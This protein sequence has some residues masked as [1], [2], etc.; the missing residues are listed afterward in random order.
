MTG[1]CFDGSTIMALVTP[2]G[3]RDAW[4]GRAAALDPTT[5]HDTHG[6]LRRAARQKHRAGLSRPLPVCYA[7]HAG[8]RP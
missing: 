6:D 8:E 3:K 5:R 4:P 7:F 1:Q 2:G